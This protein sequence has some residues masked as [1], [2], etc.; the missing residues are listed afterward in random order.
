MERMAE[1]VPDSDEQSLQHFIS[2]ADWDTPEVTAQVG[3][4]ANTLLGR[5][6]DT[7]LLIDE[8]GF[9]KKGQHSVGVARQWNGRL[10]KVD[11]CQVGVFASL[12]RGRFATLIDARLYLSEEWIS[13]KDRCRKAH[14]PVEHRTFKTKPELALEMVKEA[15]CNGL[16]YGW[17]GADGLYGNDPAFLYGLDELGETFMID[18]HKDQP[19]YIN[20]PAPYIHIV[21]HKS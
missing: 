13:D 14:I 19:I 11:N 10:G 6:E 20:D 12:S 16:S 8:S 4:E 17:V 3:R 18:I 2:N 5:C 1:V 9:E 21:I 15:R 7:A